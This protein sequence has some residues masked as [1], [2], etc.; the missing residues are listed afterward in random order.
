MGGS[1]AV[2]RVDPAPYYNAYRLF[3][4]FDM[5]ITGQGPCWI[6]QVVIFS[7]LEARR[8]ELVFMG[9]LA[10]KLGIKDVLDTTPEQAGDGK[11]QR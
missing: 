7:H 8:Y 6:R 10:L 11:S 1:G 9:V 4:R 5:G 3:L 2:G